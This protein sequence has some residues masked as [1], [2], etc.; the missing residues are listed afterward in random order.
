MKKLLSVISAMAVMFAMGGCESKEIEQLSETV[1]ETVQS[2]VDNKN[3]LADEKVIQFEITDWTMEELVTDMKI[4]SQTITLPCTATDLIEKYTLKEITYSEK[5]NYT[6]CNM[7]EG[8][9]YVAQISFNGEIKE[10]ELGEHTVIAWFMDEFHGSIPEFNIMG[11]TK[12]STREDV[13]KALGNPN[14]DAGDDSL[15]QYA[16]SE[17]KRIIIGFDDENQYR[18]ILFF[19]IYN[20]EQ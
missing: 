9:S 17:N 12:D 7:Y 18:I 4:N 20:S 8:D 2:V 6:M 14:T 16:F 5:Y 13:V 11:I 1:A 19:I 10:S 3:M 15:Y